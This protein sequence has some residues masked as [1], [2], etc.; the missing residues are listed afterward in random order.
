MFCFRSFLMGVGSVLS[1]GFPR[2]E[3]YSFEYPHKALSDDWRNVGD[4]LRVAILKYKA[5]DVNEQ[6]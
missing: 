3:R 1:F 4:D 2:I 5:E 6:A